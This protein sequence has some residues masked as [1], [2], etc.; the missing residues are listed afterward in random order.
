[1]PPDPCELTDIKTALDR[2]AFPSASTQSSQHIKRMHWYVACRL[3]LEGGFRPETIVPRPPFKSV[4]RG[5]E[6][7]LHHE[8]AVGGWGER[9]LL[10]GLKTKDMDVSICL[11]GIGP[12]LAVSL[13]G[14]HNA[15]RNLTNRMEEAG[16]DCTNLHL[17]YPALVY[18]FW[19][20]LRANDE[21][22]STPSAHFPL[23]EK[24]RYKTE[25]VAIMAAGP[26]AAAVERYA[27]ALERLS[28][29]DDLRDSPSRYEA[30]ALTLVGARRD[31]RAQVHP[32]FPVAGS[33]LDFQRMFHRL[34]ELYDRRY[35]YQA[36]SLG[37]ITSRLQWSE[38]SP[39]ISGTIL[40]NPA[41]AEFA[42]RIA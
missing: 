40:N 29:R 15:F 7:L 42:P 36:P 20:V 2:F 31:N 16:G 38:E 1:M 21:A 11:D 9:T 8:P 28:D 41:F 37:S 33:V 19:H 5:D 12:V 17:S 34:Y 24:G 13:K 32:K 3:V 10:G 39:I 27:H 26:P 35:V 18:G 23:D 6:W 4:P 30:C 22:D 14:T 25:D